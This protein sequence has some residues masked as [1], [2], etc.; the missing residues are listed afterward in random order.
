MTQKTILEVTGQAQEERKQQTAVQK[1]RARV[2]RVLLRFNISVDKLDGDF[3][4]LLEEKREQRMSL[5]EKSN[6]VRDH[7]GPLIAEKLE[8][9]K[10]EIRGQNVSF[11][12]DASPRFA[13]GF[14]V[15]L[16]WILPDLVIRQ[17]IIEFRLFDSP[18]KGQ[19][20]THLVIAAL[21]SLN[22]ARVCLLSGAT[23]R[24]ATNGVLARSLAPVFP[25]YIHS[26]C[27]AHAYDSLSKELNVSEARLFLKAW[28]KVFSKSASARDV[29]KTIALESVKR[30][31][32]IRWG[33]TT[34]QVL[35]IIRVWSFLEKILVDLQKNN[36][37]KKGVAQLAK[38]RDSFGATSNL[39]IELC[40]VA[41][42]AHHLKSANLLL[43]GDGLLAPFAYNQ[44]AKTMEMFQGIQD[45]RVAQTLPNTAAIVS[46][47]A[48][49][50]TAAVSVHV[51]QMIEPAF[52]KFK[53]VFLD[54]QRDGEAGVSL[55]ESKVIF[56]LAQV[57]QPKLCQAW[58]NRKDSAKLNIG[59]QL[60]FPLIQRFLG[61]ELC[62]ACLVEFP[63]LVVVYA[64]FASQDERPSFMNPEELRTFWRGNKDRLP[65]WYAALLRISLVCPSSAAAERG[66]SVW[67]TVI[68]DQKTNTLE[69]RQK[70]TLQEV[71][72]T[73]V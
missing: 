55:H 1:H 57:F 41:D 26:F 35:Q 72:S 7:L 65:A 33:S 20:Y 24:A 48:V 38:F 14:I 8:Y 18:L 25:A 15:I 52:Q 53:H 42:V 59:E 30:K 51:R 71:Y 6:L 16:R 3:K 58:L 17:E 23:D 64:E 54:T 39:A 28:N 13:E 5:G 34:D 27:M 50:N 31:H 69:D 10:G 56:R 40:V 73:T 22:V 29:F 46:Q 37:S 43:Q 36:Y 63:E 62:Q 44:L 21:E 68:D 66:F 2:L 9:L 32:R 12:A 47:V 19:D 45:S 49:Q 60:G 67:R 61:R 4:E 11:V 70:L